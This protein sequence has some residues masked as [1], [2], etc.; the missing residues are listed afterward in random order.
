M[1]RT[2]TPVKKTERAQGS[3]TGTGQKQLQ[4]DA[5]MIESWGLPHGYAI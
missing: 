2:N 3:M 1:K 4:G 5:E